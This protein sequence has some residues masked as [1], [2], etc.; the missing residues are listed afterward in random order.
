MVKTGKEPVLELD[1]RLDGFHEVHGKRGEAC[2]IPFHG[3]ADGPLFQGSILPGGVDTQTQRKGEARFLSARYIL[4]GVDADGGSCRIFIENNGAIGP[5]GITTRPRIFT[6][7]AVL[8]WLED[9]A[10][11]GTVE[12]NGEKRVRI[13]F[14]RTE[15]A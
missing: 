7:S 1:V 13:C 4:E 5:D 2:M 3:T 15:E 11:C 12:S 6:D 10:L 8:S 14:Y 9:A